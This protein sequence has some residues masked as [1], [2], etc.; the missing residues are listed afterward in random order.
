MTGFVGILS[1]DTAFPRIVGDVGNPASH[2]MPARVRIVGGADAA[3]IVCDGPPPE[4]MAQRFV[5]AARALEAEGAAAI[6]STCGFLIHLQDRI[7]AAVGIPVMLSALSL[8]PMAA[9]ATGGRPVGIVTASR[10]ALGPASLRAAGIDAGAVRIVGME[11]DTAFRETFTAPRSDQRRDLDRA[12]M[13]RAVVARAAALVAQEP[14]IGAIVL[15]CGNLPPYSAAIRTRTGRPVLHLL[16]GAALL[17]SA[18]R[19]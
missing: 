6:V 10:V 14:G 16:D 7:A 15:E 12:A 9:T 11:D 3:R 2:A 5:R 8:V 19:G 18:A 17:W 1:L 13:E 4:E